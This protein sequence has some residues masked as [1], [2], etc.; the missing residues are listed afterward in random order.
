[1]AFESGIEEIVDFDVIIGG[2]P[3]ERERLRHLEIDGNVFIK[4]LRGEI[5]RLAETDAF[6]TDAPSRRVLREGTVYCSVLLALIAG[7]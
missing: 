1:M 6:I 3:I 2:N 4:L 7:V 5:L